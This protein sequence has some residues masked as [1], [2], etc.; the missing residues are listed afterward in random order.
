M[1]SS[2]SKT[3]KGNTALYGIAP[4]SGYLRAF[5]T[6]GGSRLRPLSRVNVLLRSFCLSDSGL[7]APSAPCDWR[8]VS[9]A[10]D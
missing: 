2:A 6:F 8:R 1:G 10:G 7:V 4:L 9:P 3:K 5:S